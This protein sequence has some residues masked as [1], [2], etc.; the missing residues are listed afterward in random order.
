MKIGILGTGVVGNAVA[1]R[2]VQLG[3]QV[4]MGSRAANNPKASDWAKANGANA[5][6]GTFADA[7]GYGE[8]VFNCTAGTAS[9]VA[10]T[11]AGPNNFRGKILIDIANPLDFSKGMPPTLSVCN[12]DSL[13]EQIQSAFPEAKVVKTLNTVN[14]NVMVKPSLVPGDH[15]MFICGNDAT[16]KAKVTDILKSWFG[17]KSVIDLGDMTNARVMEMWVVMWI[18]LMIKFQTPNFNLKIVK[19]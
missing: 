13:G 4:K 1:T 18:R 10:L 14:C 17:W 12:T 3:H 6:H 15:D 16:A 9:L 7:A 2:L 19:A 5:S 11:L 8:I